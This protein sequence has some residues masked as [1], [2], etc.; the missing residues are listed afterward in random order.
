[1]DKIDKFCT[2]SW[3]ER[4]YQRIF[5][6]K[7]HI[8]TS[9]FTNHAAPNPPLRLLSATE[10]KRYDEGRSIFFFLN[11]FIFIFFFFLQFRSSKYL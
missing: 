1:M 3:R 2:G 5:V 4:V 9:Y 7:A 8:S 6:S 11:V 10:L